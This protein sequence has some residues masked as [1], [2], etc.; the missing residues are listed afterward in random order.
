MT[1]SE[2]ATDSGSAEVV[3]LEAEFDP[4]GLRMSRKRIRV[5]RSPIFAIARPANPH[6]GRHLA[7]PLDIQEIRNAVTQSRRSEL[8]RRS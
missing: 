1:Q 5:V 4:S 6:T 3:E 2:P 7:S 8:P